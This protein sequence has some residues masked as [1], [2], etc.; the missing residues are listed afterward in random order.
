[1][2]IFVYCYVYLDLPEPEKVMSNAIK[3]TRINRNLSLLFNVGCV[4]KSYF[5]VYMLR[6]SLLDWHLHNLKVSEGLDIVIFIFEWNN[7]AA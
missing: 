5:Y 1:M 3:S 7:S 6:N 4:S 2:L